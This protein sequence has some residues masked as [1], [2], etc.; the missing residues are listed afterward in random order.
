MSRRVDFTTGPMGKNIIHYSVSLLLASIISTTFYTADMIVVGKFVGD[1]AQAAISSTGMLRNLMITVVAGLSMGVNVRMAQCVGAKDA[2]QAD[3]VYHTGIAAAL[4]IGTAVGILCIIMTPYVLRWMQFPPNIMEQARIYMNIFFAG[5][6]IQL[7]YNLSGATLRAQGDSQR[8][9]Y[10]LIIGGVVNVVLNLILVLV[11]HMGVGSVALATVIA[12]AVSACLTI[13]CISCE[14]ELVRPE[15]KKIRIC[16]SELKQIARI[17]IPGAITSSAF[18]LSSILIQSSINSLGE[19]VVAGSGAA[20]NIGSY[21]NTA[22]TIF[23]STC[24]V[25]CAQNLGANRL[26]RV[27]QGYRLCVTLSVSV[28]IVVGVLVTAFGPCLMQLFTNDPDVVQ[29]GMVRMYSKFPLYFL[30]GVTFCAQS[31]QQALG[32]A[33]GCSVISMLGT[34]GIRVLWVLFVFPLHPTHAM[35]ILTFPVGWAVTGVAQCVRLHRIF[36]SHTLEA[37]QATT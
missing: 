10:F 34:C 28:G 8:P 21:V 24:V 18:S 7:L 15:L 9:V 1:A 35:I 31:A 26:D 5:L 20:S 3:R 32:Y 33:G 19:V 29:A 16:L 4:T 36:R 27:K 30:L 13:R 6:P 2:E 37:E 22:V 25:L 23:G 12:N 14:G 11:L 17:G